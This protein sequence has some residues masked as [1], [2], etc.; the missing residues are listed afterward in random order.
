MQAAFGNEVGRA[1]DGGCF[2]RVLQAAAVEQPLRGAV[3]KAGQR[4]GQV[5]RLRIAQIHGGDGVVRELLHRL[6]HGIAQMP[7]QQRRKMVRRDGEDGGIEC[8]PVRLHFARSSLHL[9]NAAVRAVFCAVLRQITQHGRGQRVAQIA[10]GNIKIA[11]IARSPHAVGQHMTQYA[12]AGGFRRRIQR[13]QHHRPPKLRAPV[14][15]DPL[16][17]QP[18]G[19]ALVGRLPFVP[20]LQRGHLAQQGGFLRPIRIF[21][22]QH[23][24]QQMQR[25]RQLL[26]AAELEAVRQMPMQR[27]AQEQR[28]GRFAD[29]AQQAE[30]GAVCANQQVLAVVEFGKFTVRHAACPPTCHFARFKQRESAM[31]CQI[32]GGGQA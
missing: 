17:V 14:F 25:C 15:A 6:A 27:F 2:V 22:A 12:Q 30:N 3:G 31:R 23:R 26:W 20:A 32:S 10:L 13:A 19:N 29:T 7:G 8:L 1:D 24:P 16:F 28:I 18:R 9:G 5:Q 11:R 21:A 4:G